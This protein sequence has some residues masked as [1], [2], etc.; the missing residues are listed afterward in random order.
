[1]E[2]RNMTYDLSAIKLALSSVKKLRIT[3]TALKTAR[4][5]GF[6][7]QDI[8]DAVQQI[9][10]KDFIKSMTTY[11]DHRV[12]QDVYYTEFNAILNFSWFYKQFK[13]KRWI[14][15]LFIDKPAF[16]ACARCE[17]CCF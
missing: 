3:T 11:A 12:W 15:L 13:L 7:Q 14:A 17:S 4:A 10:R 2:K 6:S 8:V 9:K 5:I 16:R 1:M